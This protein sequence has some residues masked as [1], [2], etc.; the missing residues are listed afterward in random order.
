[1]P[2]RKLAGSI[3]AAAVAIAMAA[4]ARTRSHEADQRL[5][6]P[7]NAVGGAEM[8]RPGGA[9]ALRATYD[10]RG[11]I[12]SGYRLPGTPT[13]NARQ[14]AFAVAAAA[15]PGRSGG[16]ADVMAASGRGSTWKRARAVCRRAYGEVA[17]TALSRIRVRRSAMR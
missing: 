5:A 6:A 15:S 11:L 1:M 16:G 17:G 9:P 13:R 4:Q 7:G 8:H 3:T 14:I 10:D 2:S 12:V